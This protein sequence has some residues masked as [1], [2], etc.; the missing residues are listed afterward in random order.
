MKK[1]VSEAEGQALRGKVRKQKAADSFLNSFAVCNR[2]NPIL[3]R[4]K[5]GMGDQPFNRRW[6]VKGEQR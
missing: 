6:S 2:S 5:N 3:L 1:P 4:H